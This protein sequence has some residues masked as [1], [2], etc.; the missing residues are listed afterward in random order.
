MAKSGAI[1]RKL[2]KNALMLAQTGRYEDAIRAYLRVIRSSPKDAYAAFMLGALYGNLK[3]FAA[4]AKYSRLA[5]S[6][7]SENSDGFYNLAQAE[8]HLG[9]I[10]AAVAALKEVVKLAPDHLDALNNLGYALSEQGRY[11]E[12]IPQYKRVLAI[13]H[14]HVDAL[15]S[16][17]KIYQLTGGLSK[18][19][20]LLKIALL[21]DPDS[22]DINYSLA[23]IAQMQ[24]EVPLSLSIY[25]KLLKQNPD[26]PLYTA[27]KSILL[28]KTGRFEEALELI[29]PFLERQQYTPNIARAFAKL[30]RHCDKTQEAIQ[31]IE[32]TL[33]NSSELHNID[34]MSS[35]TTSTHQSTLHFEL[36][37]LYD[38]LGNYDEAF[39]N[40]HDSHESFDNKYYKRTL[41]ESFVKMQELYTR[42]FFASAPVSTIVTSKPIFIVG[43]PRSGTTLT[44]Q[45]LSSHPEVVGGGELNDIFATS[46][47]LPVTL[48]SKYPYPECMKEI[49]TETLDMSAR[50]YLKTLDEISSSAPHV[51]DKMPHN[52]AQIGLIRLMFPDAKIIHCVRNPL[53]NCLSIYFSQFNHAHGYAADLNSLGEHYR[54]YTRLM[55]HWNELFGDHILEHRYED[56][57]ADQEGMTRRLLDFCNL[58]WDPACMQFFKAKRFVSTISYDQVRQPIYKKSV[59]R[60]RNY[61]KHLGPL[62]DSLGIDPESFSD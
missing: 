40:Y 46:I 6:L 27:A 19:R 3:Q 12:A 17:A 45:I 14:N 23:E 20:R 8:M 22:V 25:N 31:Y 37:K 62:I 39:K 33:A 30:S 42:E 32:A 7:D 2:S 11:D 10:D 18:S 26:S 55:A 48:H 34:V 29:T 28:E 59:A 60:W 1:L 53:D 58:A 47:H 15:C 36:G 13:Q 21:H 61:E 57:I 56:V 44:E 4:A 38:T 9:N 49:N 41:E 54:G 16:L 24:G 50:K 51:T 35:S 5:T 43:M 52:F